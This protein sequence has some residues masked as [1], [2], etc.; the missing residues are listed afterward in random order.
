M[1]K[2]GQDNIPPKRVTICSVDADG[3]AFDSPRGF[4][5]NTGE[6]ELEWFLRSAA[7][8]GLLSTIHTIIMQTRPDTVVYELGS[9]RQSADLD[10]YNS[11]GIQKRKPTPSSMLIAPALCD[12]FSKAYPTIKHVVDPVLMADIYNGRQGGEN[13]ALAAQ[14][15]LSGKWNTSVY[16]T[17]NDEGKLHKVGTSDNTVHEH[18]KISLVL[19]KVLR[20]AA[21]NPQARIHFNFIDDID[22][23]ILDSVYDFFTQYGRSLIPSNVTLQLHHHVPASRARGLQEK[24]YLPIQGSRDHIITN[25]EWV[26]RF[27]AFSYLENKTRP[28]HYVSLNEVKFHCEHNTRYP[29]AMILDLK[30]PGTSGKPLL[31]EHLERLLSE[32]EKAE[33]K[34]VCYSTRDQYTTPAALASQGIVPSYFASESIELVLLGD[35]C[36]AST[37]QPALDEQALLDYIAGENHPQVEL[38]LGTTQQSAFLDNR[39]G[40]VSGQ[41]AVAL[42]LLQ[43]EISKKMQDSDVKINPL[44]TADILNKKPVVGSS[45]KDMLNVA[46]GI[47]KT[48]YSKTTTDT[49]GFLTILMH[50][51]DCATRHPGKTIILEFIGKSTTEL[52]TVDTCFSNVKYLLPCNVIFK[53]KLHP[54]IHNN[55]R[56]IPINGSGIIKQ[57]FDWMIRYIA[58]KWNNDGKDGRYMNYYRNTKRP[59]AAAELNSVEVHSNHEHQNF[60]AAIELPKKFNYKDDVVAALL[61]F[62]KYEMQIN[63]RHNERQPLLDRSSDCSQLKTMELL[64]PQRFKEQ[65]VV[66][67]TLGLGSEAALFTFTVTEAESQ[68][69]ALKTK[70]NTPSRITAL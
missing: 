14:V 69:T 32:L 11:V 37:T 42:A 54:A 28:G 66:A 38:A 2:T 13:Y 43:D 70:S 50:A 63:E 9:N 39:S 17:Y 26:P 22:D 65:R 5:T 33:N 10:K 41:K 8:S 47:S 61:D 15:L 34:L 4:N 30:T 49:S 7:K 52:D 29:S 20:A 25:Y 31:V 57:N 51:H 27:L 16:N 40:Q 35:S 67:P 19:T 1:R 45:F 60:K 68:S 55:K 58:C 48:K 62:I 36:F 46:R 6:T 64:L 24:T 53:P 12:N 3:C 18:K 44:T 56:Y 21:M 23:D 59:I